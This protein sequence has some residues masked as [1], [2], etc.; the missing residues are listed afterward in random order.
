M[1]GQ[2]FVELSGSCCSFVLFIWAR[3]CGAG[4]SAVF[5][6]VLV[7]CSIRAGPD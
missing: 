3:M 1:S 7:N 2:R 4:A 6:S 5:A